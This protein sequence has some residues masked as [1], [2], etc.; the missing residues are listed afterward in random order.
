MDKELEKCVNYRR[1]FEYLWVL[2][3]PPF[4]FEKKIRKQTPP[5]PTRKPVFAHPQEHDRT[6]RVRTGK[7]KFVHPI[8]VMPSYTH[9]LVRKDVLV[10]TV[11][12]VNYPTNHHHHLL[13]H[14]PVSPKFLYFI[15]TKSKKIH[16]HFVRV[17]TQ[18]GGWCPDPRCGIR[19]LHRGVYK[20]DVAA[21]WVVH[22]FDHVSGK[23]VGVG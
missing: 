17:L 10:H 20:F 8:Q 12:R 11:S 6:I 19:I 9:T 23:N 2:D 3:L 22:C 18:R 16:Q 1:V 5:P 15:T 4:F 7:N 13:S 14:N 21:C